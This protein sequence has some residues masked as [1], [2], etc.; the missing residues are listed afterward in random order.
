MT[1]LVST[2]VCP[3]CGGGVN[4]PCFAE[5]TNGYKCFSCGISKS[6]DS[7]RTAVMGKA[8]KPTIAKDMF[9]PEYDTNIRHFSPRV[10]EWLYS[11]YVFDD[12]IRKHHIGY[13]EA[14]ADHNES[15]IL[16]VIKDNKVVYAVRRY[17]PD[18]FVLGIGDK[19]VY[20][21][22]N[23]NKK[24]IIVEDHISAIRMAEHG[25]VYCLFGTYLNKADIPALLDEY[26]DIIIWL[27]GDDAGK[28]GSRKLLNDLNWQISNNKWRYPLKYTNE[29]T[30]TIIET[31]EDPKFYSDSEIQGYLYANK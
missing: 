8:A 9:L 14:T 23:G 21:I 26:R 6:Y 7:F 25:D 2:G 16:P 3:Y 31:D 1:N 17:F 20:K 5:Y 12:M 13:I 29:W 18:K 28:K 24:L 10:L 30:L 19:Q 15:L 4:T 22:K 27:D 11:Y